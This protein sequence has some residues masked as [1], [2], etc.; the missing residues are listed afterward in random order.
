M[1]SWGDMGWRA[2]SKSIIDVTDDRS[3]RQPSVG[4]HA[5]NLMSRYDMGL[6]KCLEYLHLKRDRWDDRDDQVWVTGSRLWLVVSSNE[7]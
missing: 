2:G 7:S 4:R 6:P 5:S 3:H 1:A